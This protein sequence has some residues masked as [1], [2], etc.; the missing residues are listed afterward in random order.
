MFSHEVLN[1]KNWETIFSEYKISLTKL[2]FKVYNDLT[3]AC[4]AE[5][6]NKRI[7]KYT[8]PKSHQLNTPRYHTNIMKR[9]ISHRGAVLC[10]NIAYKC[11]NAKSDNVKALLTEAKKLASFKNFSFNITSSET[12][13]NMLDDFI[14]VWYTATGSHNYMCY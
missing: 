1:S 12:T 11:K 6:I 2:I 14:Y 8:P 9:S 10:N 5:V 7:T 4:M 13:T 3:P